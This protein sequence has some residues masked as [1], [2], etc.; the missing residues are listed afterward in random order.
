LCFTAL[1]AVVRGEAT[2]LVV[3]DAAYSHGWKE[4]YEQYSA[5]LL[6]AGTN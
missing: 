2:P 3:G 1:E 5:Q 4:L 6:P